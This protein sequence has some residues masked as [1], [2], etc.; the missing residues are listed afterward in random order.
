MAHPEPHPK[1]SRPILFYI[2]LTL[3]VAMLASFL[4]LHPRGPKS[5]ATPSSPTSQH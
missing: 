1:Q 2:L 5:G 4:I 3:I